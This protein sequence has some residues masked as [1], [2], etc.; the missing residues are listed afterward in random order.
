MS[1]SQYLAGGPDWLSHPTVRSVVLGLLIC[2]QAESAFPQTVEQSARQIPVVREVDVVVIGGS[3]GG[4]SAAVAAA[5]TGCKVFLAAPRPYLGEDM[6]ATLYLWLEENETPGGPLTQQ[7]FR[8]RR[9]STPLRV[10]KVLEQ[11][12]LRAGVEFLPCSY[13]TDVVTDGLGVP[14]GVVIANRAGRQAVIAKVMIDATPTAC[15]AKMAGARFRDQ[16]GDT[17]EYRRVVLGGTGDSKAAHRRQIPCTVCDKSAEMSYFE[18]ALRLSAPGDDW[19]TR[20]EAEQ[21]ARDLTYRKGQQ[22]AS[23]QL[24]WVSPAPIISRTNPNDWRGLAKAEI[25]HFQPR[26]MDQFYV[27]GAAADLPREA[28]D[29]LNRPG[30]IE[31]IGRL[32]GRFAGNEAA[33][34]PVPTQLRVRGVQSDPVSTGEV[35]EVLAGLRPVDTNSK[36]IISEPSGLSVL[37]EYEVV[38]VGGGTSGAA[39]AIGAARQGVRTLVVEYQEGLGGT[40][41]LGLIGKPYRGNS[42]GFARDV[43]FPN[44]GF[45][46]EDKMEWLRRQVRDAKGDVWFLTLGCG[47]F[48]DKQQVKGVVVA[49]PWGRGVVLADVVIDATGNADVAVAA[50]A[51]SMYGADGADI[52]MQGAG[53]PVRPLGEHYV[54]TDYLLVDESDMVDVWR[55]LV[56]AKL[57]MADDVYDVGP[58]IQTRE[59]RRIVGD[60]I[61]CYLDQIAG[62]TYSDSIVLSQS[63]Y[64]SHG[65]P[66]HDYFALLP[67]DEK[68]RRANHPAP[69][70]SCYTPY[71][72]LLP[73][74][75]DG[76]LVTG[77]GISMHRDASAMMRMQPDVINQGYAAGV[78]AAMAVKAQVP[79][80][81]INVKVLQRH[82][83]EIGN[84]PK[85]VIN[86]QDSFPLSGHQVQQAV[87]SLASATNPQ[88]AARPL[89]VILSHPE[90]A[91]PFLCEAYASST[92]ETRL[93]YAKLLAFLGNKD[94][95][96]T[97]VASLDAVTEWDDRILQ[98]KMA[99][100]AYLPTPVDAIILA[101]GH[102]RDVRAL[103]AILRKLESL[104]SKVTLSHHRS[105]AIALEHLAEPSAA[106]PLARLLEKPGMQGHA[107]T[108]LTPLHDKKVDQRH[109]I[110]PLREITLAR[111]LYHCGDC[112]GMGRR[113]LTEYQS[114]L[115]GLFSRHARAILEAE[116]PT[117]A[118]QTN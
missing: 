54:N 72:C 7:I 112:D 19:G 104:D 47:A 86:H 42:V 81:E 4:V 105:V 118:K 79:P 52:A 102:S 45:T 115:R 108:K 69:G 62:R 107:M 40:G 99:E 101:L 100:Y 61:L 26:G 82:L 58:L 53:L 29:V 92:G 1:L 67:H 20:A 78:A 27:V 6:G 111:A 110:G 76:I 28:L 13:P 18:Y 68:S 56:G 49:T 17:V 15:V 48:V 36:K 85:E 25:K 16:P 90:S 63:D 103:P 88:N 116:L 97:L 74:G 84:L 114:D 12:L 96:P 65:Y 3:T 23:E 55:T 50:G 64:D 109:R 10:K 59:R 11:S 71:R 39:A 9:M 117:G 33:N 80:R 77:L 66:S 38:V 94:A 35:R 22:R 98:G 70:G 83:V 73:Q 57:S 2:L 106:E 87:K 60:H 75:L 46:V 30:T 24:L 43:P 37:G 14:A 41:T 21:Q 113:I 44:Q 8:D 34:M 32:V 93:T 51:P 91:L 89:A 31:E 95:V 5:Q